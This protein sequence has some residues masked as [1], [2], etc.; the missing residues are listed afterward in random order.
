L[1]DSLSSAET[2]GPAPAGLARRKYGSQVMAD[3]RQRILAQAQALIDEVG[4]EGFTIRDLSRR[5]DVAPRTLYNLFGS[6]EDIVASAIHDH[7]AGLLANVSPPPPAADFAENL[8]RI[9]TLLDRTIELKRYATAMVGV[10]FSP[11]V[12][13]RL[14]DT[15]RWISEGGSA[16]WVPR[17]VEDGVLVRLLP[18]D[19]ERLSTLLVNT[20]YANITDWAAGRI[21]AEELKLRY[22]MNFLI[23][24]Q[25]L[26]RPLY[27]AKIGA[28]LDQVRRGEPI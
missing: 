28:L 23:C 22:K 16:A 13:R 11:A 12:D 20:G 18:E 4:V 17:A 5:A 15:L 19:R 7:F 14:Y 1:T 6:K 8:R 10:F 3:R 9:D 2:D 27:R 24:I 25:P 21:S 26:S